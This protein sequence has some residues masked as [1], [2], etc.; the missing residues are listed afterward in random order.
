[1]E[2]I[3]NYLLCRENPKHG[4]LIRGFPEG[5]VSQHAH[6][7]H[8]RQNVQS[9]DLKPL[10]MVPTDAD[11]RIQTSELHLRRRSKTTKRHQNSLRGTAEHR[12]YVCNRYHSFSA[13]VC[14][15]KRLFCKGG[16]QQSGRISDNM[17]ALLHCS[18]P[19]LD[20]L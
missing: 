14:A 3:I 1:M 5:F 8:L 20:L 16:G 15:Q 12:L 10:D 13:P 7:P 17:Q 11:G 2:Q 18:K 6:W 9:Q 19:A 4:R